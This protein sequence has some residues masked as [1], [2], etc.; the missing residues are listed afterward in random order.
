MDRLQTTYA[1][2]LGRLLIASLF[3]WAG[4]G[5]L[6][7]PMAGTVGYIASVGLPLPELGFAVALI[8]ELGGGILILL[9]FGTR[10]VAIVMAAFCLFTA[11]VFHG[12]GGDLSNQMVMNNNIHAFKNLAMAGGLLFVFAHGAGAWS[13]D[14]LRGH[15]TALA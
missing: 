15:R 13:L 6:M 3:I 4:F 7:A 2:V 8:V 1:P 11:F 5:K 9:G 10:Y 14:A 12:F